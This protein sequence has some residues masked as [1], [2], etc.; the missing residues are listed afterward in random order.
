MYADCDEGEQHYY[1]CVTAM[2]EQV[3]RLRAELKALDVDENTMVWFCSDNGPEGQTGQK[4]RQRGST[5]GL[6]GR[7]RS[8]FNGGVG[9]PACMVWPGRVTAGSVS[10]MPCSTLDYFPTVMDVMGYQMPDERP[11]DGISLVPVLRGEMTMRPIPIPYRFLN[12]KDK[13][14]GAPTIAM[15]GNQFK[16]LT[17]LSDTG[18][19]D[20]VYDLLADPFEMNNV[21]DSQR[22][23]ASDMQTAL[24]EWLV[25]C[26]HSHNGDDY[27]EPF[28]PVFSFEEVS[29]DWSM[30]S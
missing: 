6:R 28:T 10:E 2:D 5:A 15:I 11:I 27:S 3:G 19:E 12:Q 14:F 22:A 21:I 1:G 26:E 25:S 16:Y 17:N 7:K 8:L 24:R 20:L 4:G 13:M 23:F 29:G 18:E 9:V 30:R